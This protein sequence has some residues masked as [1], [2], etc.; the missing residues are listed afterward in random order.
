MAARLTEDTITIATG[1]GDKL[2]STVRFIATFVIG[3]ALGF[4]HSWAVTL[5]V[6]ATVPAISILMFRLKVSTERYEAAVAAAY[7]RAG[8]VVKEALSAVRLVLAFGGVETEVARY[9]THLAPA[10]ENSSK[11]GAGTHALRV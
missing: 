3:I 4:Y 10:Q 1:I 5:V 2:T 11:K 6:F 7:A 9:D 8:D